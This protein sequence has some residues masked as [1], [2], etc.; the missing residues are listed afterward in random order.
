MPTNFT[1]IPTGTAVTGDSDLF[2][3]RYQELD[4]AIVELQ[5]GEKE[6]PQVTLEAPTTLSIASDVITNRTQGWHLID[7]EL[8]APSDSL[9]AITP[10][11]DGMLL[12]QIANN[13]RVVTLNHDAV[14]GNLI[15]RSGLDMLMEDTSRVVALLGSTSLNKWFE[16]GIGEFAIRERNGTALTP[17]KQLL[18]PDGTLKGSAS[19]QRRLAVSPSLDARRRQFSLQASAATIQPVGVIA[20]TIANSPANANSANGPYITLPS[21]ASAGNIAGFVS[22][23]F[24][25]LRR[26]WN[27]LIRWWVETPASNFDALRYWV[28]IISA[29]VTNV[30]TIAGATEFAGFRYST[31]AADAGWR[32]VTKDASTQNTGA[33]IGTITAGAAYKLEM[34]VDSAAGKVFFSVNDSAEVEL[35]ANLPAAATELGFICRVIPT[36]AN[37]R[38]LNFGAMEVL[39][40]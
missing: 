26:Q 11:F 32:P 14:G 24:N 37:I 33:A 5:L 16:V 13:A 9:K 8:S 19:R 38:Q 31:V 1:P 30:D 3:T 27:P 39:A 22:T 28:G 40:V 20:P 6:L 18:V 10:V 21:T 34:R 7:T 29:D 36:T 25:L 23:T 4:D 2:N 15:L 17:I 35:N 12:I